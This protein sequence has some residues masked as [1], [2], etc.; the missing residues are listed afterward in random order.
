MVPT[1]QHP[2]SKRFGTRIAQN[3]AFNHI[4]DPPS[5]HDWDIK[6]RKSGPI[7]LEPSSLAC[8]P[9]S[10]EIVDGLQTFSAR[11]RNA[12]EPVVATSAR[13]LKQQKRADAVTLVWVSME[14]S[15][16]VLQD[17][18]STALRIRNS[19]ARRSIVAEIGE[20]AG[21]SIQHVRPV[22]I[23]TARAE[24]HEEGRSPWTLRPKAAGVADGQQLPDWIVSDC[25][26]R[27]AAVDRVEVKVGI[28]QLIEA[29]NL[30]IRTGH[31][32]R[33]AGDERNTVIRVVFE[34]AW[35]RAVAT[36]LVLPE[37]PPLHGHGP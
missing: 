19:S 16:R 31:R 3:I 20:Q 21:L 34:P 13:A 17:L 6:N 1:R 36:C 15:E 12:K 14:T 24:S 29:D 22:V 32:F 23:T 30:R 28:V 35:A 9:Q 25:S 8:S 11:N 26:R 33:M 37:Q 7:V 2:V 5:R 18:V 27:P 10:N 4:A